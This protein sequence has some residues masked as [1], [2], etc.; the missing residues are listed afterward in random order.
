MSAPRVY[1]SEVSHVRSGDA[2]V[3]RQLLRASHQV[4]A[5]RVADGRQRTVGRDGVVAGASEAGAQGQFVDP[6]GF[7]Q[8]LLVGD[9]PAEGRR[10]EESPFL[11]G[12]EVRGAVVTG[13]ERNV[14]TLLVVVVQTSEHRHL[15]PVRVVGADR[16]VLL[17]GNRGH[18][19]PGEF[20]ERIAAPG[21]AQVVVVLDLRGVSAQHVEIV[22][23]LGAQ[24]VVDRIFA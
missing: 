20:V 1:W 5:R 12:G 24:F 3:D 23:A 8:E 15:G 11:V 4:A 19:V 18:V 21:D 6:L 16:G 2:R 9:V 10:G 17:V 13:R 22:A 14:V 7:L